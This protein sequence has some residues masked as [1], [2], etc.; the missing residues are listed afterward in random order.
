VLAVLAVLAVAGVA[1]PWWLRPLMRGAGL[2]R[3][4]ANVTAYRSRLAELEADAAA[5]F[6]APDAVDSARAEL[7][8]HLLEDLAGPAATERPQA[9]RRGV[10]VLAT[11]ALLLFA[12]AWYAA[13]GSWRTQALVDL[14]RADP[15]AAHDASLQQMASRLQEHVAEEPQDAE[16]WTWLART[17]RSL[18]RQAEA[19]AAF[20]QA[21]KLKG[22]QD[23]DLLADE[24]EAL[25]LAQDRALA[26]APADRF[27]QALAVAPDH[28]RALF[29]SGIAAMQAG[30]DRAAIAHWERLLR[31]DLPGDARA[32]LEQSL[33]Q[34]RERS[35]TPAPRAPEAAAASLHL[36]VTLAPD[37]APQV[38]PDDTLF[39]YASDAAGPRMPLAVRRFVA[40]DL[41]LATTLDDSHGMAGRTLSAA[42]RWRV[43]ARVSRSGSATP[44]AGDLQ[45]EIVVSRSGPGQRVKLEIDRPLTD[46]AP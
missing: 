24:G 32:T 43:V 18:G 4:K 40:A 23:P 1:A 25:A 3:R 15:Q 17:Y 34:L 2:S 16:A 27:A 21:S 20:G 29:Y 39:I 45:G 10:P 8:A 13:A 42:Q 35:G 41:P 26:G 46:G 14:S 7:G 44:Q 33:A 5:G 36:E 19:A 11:L 12:G 6:L 9:S 31:Q 22:G 37:L 38:R 30:D 28:P